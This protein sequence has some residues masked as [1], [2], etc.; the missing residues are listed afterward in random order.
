MKYLI[1][2][3]FIVV[4]ISATLAIQVQAQVPQIQYQA[5]DALTH[6]PDK[7]SL[8]KY[9]LYHSIKGEIYS[10]LGNDKIADDCFKQAENLTQSTHEKR[11][12][13]ARRK[14]AGE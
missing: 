11:F 2:R 3:L 9:Y 8:E 7:K 14:K 13:T 5:E 4:G 12:L 10:R 6:I 1:Q